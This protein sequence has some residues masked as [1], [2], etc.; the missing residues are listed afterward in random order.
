[1]LG[2]KPPLRAKYWRAGLERASGTA[3]DRWGPGQ[4]PLSCQRPS[5]R[6]PRRRQ[7]RAA[8]IFAS[9]QRLLPVFISGLDG[10]LSL[11]Y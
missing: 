5:I 9:A 10:N 11:T 3:P 6:G 7:F 4:V 8:P 1:M 2:E